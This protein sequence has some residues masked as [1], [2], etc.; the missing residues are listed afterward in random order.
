[1]KST[2][3]Y[4]QMITQYYTG[5][6][7]IYERSQNFYWRT[8]RNKKLFQKSGRV[9]KQLIKISTLSIQQQTHRETDPGHIP[10]FNSQNKH[11]HRGERHL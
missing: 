9:Q 10:I 3:H 6:N 11:N 2:C 7:I 5:Y 1:M 8:F 4:L